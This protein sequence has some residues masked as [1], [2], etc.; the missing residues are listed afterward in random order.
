MV[1]EQESR[2]TYQIHVN[3]NKVGE[4]QI[5]DEVIATIAALAATEV[6]GVASMSG[7]ITKE[8]VNKLGKKNLSRGVKIEVD[9]ENV[10]VDLALQ[11]EYGY[12]IPSVS[13]LVQ[14][15]VKSAIETMTGLTVSMVNIR[16]V[17]VNIEKKHK[18]SG[19][20]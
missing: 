3:E 11:V 20:N 2:N 10:E 7:N 17:S 19:T 18:S 8:L 15:K 13:Q 16:I 12:S 5:A 4:V 14:E 1:R 6:E 9:T